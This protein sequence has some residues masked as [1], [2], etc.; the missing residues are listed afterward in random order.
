MMIWYKDV[1]LL[2][3]EIRRSPVKVGSLSYYLQGFIRFH[4]FW[5]GAGFQPSTVVSLGES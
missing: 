1:I 3:E 2:M 4:K 5:G